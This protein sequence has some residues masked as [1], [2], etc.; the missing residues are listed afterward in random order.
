MAF[1]SFF[2]LFFLLV[3]ARISHSLPFVYFHGTGDSCSSENSTH[4]VSYLKNVT[5]VEGECM[6]IGNG[7]TDSVFMPINQQIQIACDKVK[8]AKHLRN[9]FN[10]FGISQGGLISRGVI[11]FCDGAPPVNNLITLATPHAG[12]AFFPACD[13]FQNWCPLVQYVWDKLVYTDLVQDHIALAAHYKR[14]TMIKEYLKQSRLLPKLNNEHPQHRNATYNK[15]FSSLTTLVL[16]M[17]EGDIFA[18]PRE[19]SWFGYYKDGSLK[20]LLPADE[21]QLYKEDWIGL[22]IL[23]ESGRVKRLKVPGNHAEAT[24]KDLREFVAPFLMENSYNHHNPLPLITLSS[25]PTDF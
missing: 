7:A 15:R 23:N 8:E 25:N 13:V 21:T 19:S 18:K 4:I 2:L 11:Q 20:N 14:P 5:G 10:L 24:D 17:N 9:G 1:R 16:L 12:L 3:L 6:E 22:K